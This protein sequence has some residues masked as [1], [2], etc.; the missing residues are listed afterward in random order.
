MI[1]SPNVDL[2]LQLE[3]PPSRQRN[4]PMH[5]NSDMLLELPSH[6]GQLSPDVERKWAHYASTPRPQSRHKSPPDAV[7]LDLPPEPLQGDRD[8]QP[9]PPDDIYE[10]PP[11]P[12]EERRRAS[13]SHDNQYHLDV[14]AGSAWGSETNGKNEYVLPPSSPPRPSASAASRPDEASDSA[15]TLMPPPPTMMSTP[16]TIPA[17]GARP[18]AGGMSEGATPRISG[19]ERQL[20]GWS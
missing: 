13:C 19:A 6:D 12:K 8:P 7:F 11:S 14:S 4:L 2:S 3:R 5:L 1:P 16:M 18:M 15:A 10:L 17:T 9:L 20:R